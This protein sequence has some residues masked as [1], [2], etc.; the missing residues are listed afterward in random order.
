MVCAGTTWVIGIL[1][2]RFATPPFS[3]MSFFDSVSPLIENANRPFPPFHSVPVGS[4]SGGG[5]PLYSARMDH[6]GQPITYPAPTLPSS[7]PSASTTTPTIAVP[8]PPNSSSSQVAGPSFTNG[9]AEAGPSQPPPLEPIDV[10]RQEVREEWD[11]H[12]AGRKRRW[13]ALGFNEHQQK[14]LE[15]VA[16]RWVTR[17][18]PS[19]RD[20]RLTS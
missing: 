14:D 6:S 16:L 1:R 12:V 8:A 4:Q 17:L 7:G 3:Q 5:P 18:I 2:Q 19:V 9:H 11:K 13:R 10:G 20:Q 15:G